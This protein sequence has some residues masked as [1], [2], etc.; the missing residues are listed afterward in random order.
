MQGYECKFFKGLART[1]IIFQSIKMEVAKLWLE[2]QEC[3]REGL[4]RLVAEAGFS[5]PRPA[6]VEHGGV[7]DVVATRR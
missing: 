1:R 3:S 6:G 5:D 7:F 4:W 2:K